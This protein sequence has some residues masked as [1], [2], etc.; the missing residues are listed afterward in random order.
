MK[1][2]SHVRGVC[3]CVCMHAHKLEER[4]WLERERG[5]RAFSYSLWE[6]GCIFF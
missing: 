4:Q 6:R 2:T 1:E 5:E 3:A